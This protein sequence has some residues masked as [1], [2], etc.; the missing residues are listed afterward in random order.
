MKT[1]LSLL[2]VF[3][4]LAQQPA[5]PPAATPPAATPAEAPSAAPA[6]AAPATATTVAAP[7]PSP[8]P[9]AENWLTGYI[10]LGYR[11]TG[12]GGSLDTYRSIVDLGAGPKLI[13]ADFTILDPKHR[14]FDRLRVRAYDWGDD[15][16]ESLH[17]FAEKLHWY[18]FQADYRR[19]AYF[20]NLPAFANPQL[21]QGATLDQQSFDTR[22][23]L[24]SFSL[25]ILPEKWI[26]PY[27]A[28]DRDSSRGSGVTVFESSPDS[29][30]VPD[31]TD[32]STNLYRGGVQIKGRR[33]HLTLEEGGTTFKSDQDTY[34][35]GS[36]QGN[37]TAPVF[38]E[39][40]GLTG[41]VQA[42]G[43]RGTSTF[44]KA[45]ITANPFSWLDVYA[46]VLY[47]EPKDNVNYTQFNTG[48]LVL[49]SQLLFYT[50][51]QYLASAAATLPHT[52][53]NIGW[54]IRP[55][56][57]IRILQSWSTDRLHN[58]GSAAET[59]TLLSIGSSNVIADALESALATNYSQADTSI[60]AEVSRTVNVRGGYRYVWGEANDSVLPAEGLITI[61]PEFMHRQVGMGALT[62]R[63]WEKL[64][65]TGEF[66]IGSSGGAY[67]RTSLY[68]Y[69]K[70][71]AMGRYQLL[72]TLHLSG[73]YNVI[74]NKNPTLDESYKF[75]AHQESASITW[76]PK[77]KKFD[78]EGSYEH[79]G[80]HS[81]ISYLIPQLLTSAESTYTE[82]CHTVSALFNLNYKKAKLTAGGSAVLT[83]GSQPT[84]YYQPVAKITVPVTKSL[85]FFGEWRYY[86][87]GEAFYMFESFRANTFT[88]GLRFSR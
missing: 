56:H 58:S 8:V 76:I 25:N 38:G 41:L 66:E 65:F 69:K 14:L 64:S 71:R 21:G 12:I 84:T 17:V 57:R 73:D 2:I 39:T 5:T 13:G 62:W 36:N 70:V 78:F 9:S 20:N 87:F 88:T 48:N 46:H 19:V 6:T 49:E 23:T 72:S 51:E 30:A 59:D 15:P 44:T 61:S 50:G 29:F 3:P 33:F 11:F 82:Y 60:L 37:D 81:Q 80:Y 77:G 54:E 47:S 45:I 68:N 1:L 79:C 83:S 18:E 31:Q 27:L 35:S 86:G 7:T 34:A 63:P 52:S 16:Y 26:S 24:G 75:L 42:Y 32:D 74:S 53:A 10:E 40:L 28:Y 85:G 4:L 67:F 43:I 22:R 55:V